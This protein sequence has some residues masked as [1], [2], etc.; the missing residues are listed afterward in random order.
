MIV[1]QRV[2]VKTEINIHNIKEIRRNDNLLLATLIF[3]PKLYVIVCITNIRQVRLAAIHASEIVFYVVK[4]L[5]LLCT[6]FHAE[7]G[8]IQGQ[9]NRHCDSLLVP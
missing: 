2:N 3:S 8:Y 4:I 7:F 9:R 5:F 6:C 1:Q